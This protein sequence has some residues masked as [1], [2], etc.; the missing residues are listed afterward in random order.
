[1][2]SIKSITQ[3][4]PV[5]KPAPPPIQH[6]QA[7]LGV[8]FNDPILL[9]SALTHR[10][11]LN[12]HPLE[13]VEDNE[14]L[15]F[16][17]D[18]ALDFIVGNWLY[19]HTPGFAEGKMT[20]LRASLV[21]K[22][23]LAEIARELNIGL[24]LRLGKGEEEGGGRE[25]ENNLCGA[26]EAVCGAMYLDRGLDAVREFILPHLEGRLAL[27][28]REESDKDAK[29]R[30]QEWSQ[31]NLNKTPYYRVVSLDGPEHARSFTIEVL[32]DDQVFGSGQGTSKRAAEQEAARLALETLNADDPA[33]PID[34]PEHADDSDDSHEDNVL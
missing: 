28:L 21:R 4:E 26:L 34:D 15:E 7:E 31:S 13:T 17:G 20:R 29:S 3:N 32:I 14:R 2:K 22:E 10:S 25:R 5:T 27:I 30:F 6:Y 18:A 12:E 19:S 9:V 23:T 16:L 33:S 11:Y 1:M 8:V 24:I